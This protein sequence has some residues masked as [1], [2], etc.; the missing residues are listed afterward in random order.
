VAK[1]SLYGVGDCFG[2]DMS[3]LAMTYL[4]LLNIIVFDRPDVGGKVFDEIPV[5]HNS[6][7]RSFEVIQGLLE[8]C[9]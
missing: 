9:T 3:A 8:P 5:M 6:Q 7:Y 1:Q 4:Y 2:Q